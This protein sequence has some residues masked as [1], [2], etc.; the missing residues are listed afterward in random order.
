MTD[1]TSKKLIKSI[2][3]QAKRKLDLEY[4]AIRKL[5]RNKP[6]NS[7]PL[8]EESFPSSDSLVNLE[9]QLSLKDVEILTLKEEINSLKRKIDLISSSNDN[10]RAAIPKP[11]KKQVLKCI[12]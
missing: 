5:H 3:V 7:I 11:A 8:L 10:L 4:Q 9:V 2:R 6:K 1:L 12:T